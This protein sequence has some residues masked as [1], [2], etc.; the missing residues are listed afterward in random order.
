[1]QMEKLKAKKMIALVSE[2]S[3]K[4]VIKLKE[5]TSIMGH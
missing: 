5:P 4:L 2:T 1:M 3:L